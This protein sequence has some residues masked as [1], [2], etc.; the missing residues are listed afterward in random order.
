M[1]YKVGDKVRIVDHWNDGCYQNL[2]GKMDKWLGKV[3]TIREVIDG[4]GLYRMKEDQ[5]DQGR[6]VGWCW[7]NECIA[8]LAEDFEERIVITHNKKDT[9]A[10]YYRDGKCIRKAAAHCHKDDDFD[11]K[12]GAEIAFNRLIGMIP[13]L[14]ASNEP[15]TK[16]YVDEKVN[17]AVQQF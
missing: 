14:Y 4:T 5:N 15:L 16:T 8:S 12:R 1:N 6:S 10:R 9:V 3:M 11:F 7:S 13:S 2:E 17:A